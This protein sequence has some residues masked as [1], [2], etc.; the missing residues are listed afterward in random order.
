MDSKD[1]R[2]R[3]TPYQRQSQI[4]PLSRREFLRRMGYTALFVAGAPTLL[5][6]CGGDDEA[7]CSFDSTNTGDNKTINFANWPFYIDVLEDGWFPTTS[8]EDFQA[9]S[10]INVDYVE[11]VNDNDSWFGKVQ[12]QMTACADIQRDLTVLTDWMAAR[13]IRLG[14]AEEINYDN[15][16]N[17]SN[18]SDSLKSPG[19]DPDRTYTLPWQSGLTAIGYNP[20]LTGRELTSINDIFDPAFAGK[21]TMLTEMRDTLGLVMLGMDID[22]ADPSLSDAEAAT[23]KIRE[24]V[25]NGHIRRFTGNDYG[26]DLANGNVAAAF[27]WS[28]DIIQ[29]QIDNP[30]LRFVIPDEGLMLWSDNML[31]PA[32]AANKEAAELYMNSVYDPRVAA[33]IES[34]VNFICP[35]KG[36]QQAM[37]D[38]GA[39]ID[40][41]DLV[42]LADDPL[43]F[44]DDAT[45]SKTHIFKNLDEQEERDFNDLFQAVIGA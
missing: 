6:A 5:A 26:D 18:L 2:R 45:L 21:V 32:G 29:L 10:G 22:P 40:D 16:P 38:L 25:D 43:I 37:R 34:W 4:D 27:A 35:V 41:E 39:E 13:F 20:N 14:W 1:A 42:A 11:E 12:G 19:F 33:K 15:I 23:D 17:A 24:Y 31:I 28:G 30:D 36:A 8:L 3:L 44:P 9:A 7:G